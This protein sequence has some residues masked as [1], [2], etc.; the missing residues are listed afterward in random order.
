MRRRISRRGFALADFLTGTMIFAG[1]LVG[2]TALTRSKFDLI[3]QASA[4]N[5]ATGHLEA[6]LDVLR[7]DGLPAKPDLSKTD[8]NGYQWVAERKL[9]LTGVG[10]ATETTTVRPL[11]H[12]D[13]QG[14]RLVE[15]Q[16]YEVR[17]EL[18]WTGGRR[19]ISSALPQGAK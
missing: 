2:F 17:V 14:R 12:F 4:E 10:P 18:T 15:T 3:H 7:R 5:V 16:V 1:A 19:S 6:T 11:V 9:N 8:R 13:A